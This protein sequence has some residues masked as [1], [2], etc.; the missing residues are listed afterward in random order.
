MFSVSHGFLQEGETLDPRNLSV[1]MP[2]YICMWI[3]DKYV[4]SICIYQ[5]AY[6][7][8]PLQMR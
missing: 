1:Q 2:E 6:D 7:S 3:M 8:L 4:C 5:H